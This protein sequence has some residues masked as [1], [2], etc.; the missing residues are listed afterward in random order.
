MVIPPTLLSADGQPGESNHR[1]SRRP[2][3][4]IAQ[5]VAQTPANASASQDLAFPL[6]GIPDIG[7]D[8]VLVPFVRQADL[9][10]ADRIENARFCRR[11]GVVVT[12]AHIIRRCGRARVFQMEHVQSAGAWSRLHCPRG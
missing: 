11:P 9:C 3:R 8:K 4:C 2:T 6:G 5:P 1:S 12:R 7:V 10:V